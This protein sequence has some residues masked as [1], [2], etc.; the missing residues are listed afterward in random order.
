MVGDDELLGKEEAEETRKDEGVIQKKVY[1]CKDKFIAK[2][3]NF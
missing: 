2:F 1:F 3:Y